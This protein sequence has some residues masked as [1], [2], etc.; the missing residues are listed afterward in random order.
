MIL[1]NDVTGH[2]SP[3]HIC[4][5]I[6]VALGAVHTY[7]A[8]CCAALVKTQEAFYHRSAATRNVCVNGQ[9]GLD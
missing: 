5:L 7:A 4:S 1:R 9:L 2:L 8:R 3:G 6:R